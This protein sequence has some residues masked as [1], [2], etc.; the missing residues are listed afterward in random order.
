MCTNRKNRNKE[1]DVERSDL[2]ALLSSEDLGLM[3]PA[4]SESQKNARWCTVYSEQGIRCFPPVL[5]EYSIIAY[6][7]I[8]ALRLRQ[9]KILYHW[10]R[11]RKG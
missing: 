1:D 7:G 11:S 5:Q 6:N 10:V 8:E 9:L 3:R 4:G 2:V